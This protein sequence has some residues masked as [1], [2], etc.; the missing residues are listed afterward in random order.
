MAR[1]R[2]SL[3]SMLLAMPLFG[4]AAAVL[5]DELRREAETRAL[6]ARGIFACR[7]GDNHVAAFALLFAAGCSALFGR[8]MLC[9]LLAAPG[10]LWV[11]NWLWEAATEI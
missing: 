6:E 3:R 9:V 5:A 2:F 8:Y 11:V 7:F 1:F 10:I 4:I